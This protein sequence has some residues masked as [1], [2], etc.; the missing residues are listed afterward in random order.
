YPRT[1][2]GVPTTILVASQN[3]KRLFPNGSEATDFHLVPPLASPF[4]LKPAHRTWIEHW[5]APAALPNP[6]CKEELESAN[7]R[8]TPLSSGPLRS[9]TSAPR[10]RAG[11]AGSP[12]QRPFLCSP[13][14]TP[15]CRHRI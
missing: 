7:Y 8:R 3:G 14:M 10:R 2:V 6:D 5:R 12:L 9:P 15:R 13:R 1:S 11:A 4:L